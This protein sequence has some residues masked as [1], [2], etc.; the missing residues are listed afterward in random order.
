VNKKHADTLRVSD[1]HSK[2]AKPEVDKCATAIIFFNH[3]VDEKKCSSCTCNKK[4]G[5]LC[6]NSLTPPLRPS[7]RQQSLSALR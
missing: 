6:D 2:Y 5:Y 4:K 7:K 1:I 3:F